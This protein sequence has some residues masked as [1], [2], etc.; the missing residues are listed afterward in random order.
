MTASAPRNAINSPDLS[1]QGVT[2]GIPLYNEERYIE[3]TIRSAAPQC[4]VLLVADNC[5]TDR[6]AD[7]CQSLAKEY[8]NLVFVRH[9]SNRGSAYNFEFVMT[10]ATTPYFMWLGAHDLIPPNYVECLRKLIGRDSTALLAYCTARHIDSHG[11]EIS[12]HTYPFSRQLAQSEPSKRFHAIIKY[13]G[14][15]SLIHGLFRTE[16]LK[17]AW[18][19]IQNAMGDHVLRARGGDHVLLAKLTISGKFLYTSSTSLMRRDVHLDDS[20]TKQLERITGLKTRPASP[21]APYQVMQRS[22][23]TLAVNE[24]GNRGWRSSLFCSNIRY[25]LIVR[26]GPFHERRIVRFLEMMVFQIS[27]PL[28]SGFR[29][30]SRILWKLSADSR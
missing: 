3:A 8:P 29:F 7:I 6:S 17:S 4:E 10:E 23:Y 28:Q 1:R 5:S 9:A 21:L 25:W 2:I 30:A 22:R 27:R 12:N 16:D 15:C 24:F 20:P 18:L 14:D 19:D 11:R 26:F 13:L